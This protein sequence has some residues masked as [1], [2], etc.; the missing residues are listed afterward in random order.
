VAFGGV[1]ITLWAARNDTKQS[2]VDHVT[3]SNLD[4]EKNKDLPVK[5]YTF[6][7]TFKTIKYILSSTQAILYFFKNYLLRFMKGT[8]VYYSL[9]PESPFL[10]L[11]RRRSGRGKV[12]G[13]AD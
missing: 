5:S 2:R 12:A 13:I 3:V 1:S 11:R 6:K 7:I 10:L 4:G 9:E 8:L